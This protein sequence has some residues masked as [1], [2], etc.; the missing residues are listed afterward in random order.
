[1]E[2]GQLWPAASLPMCPQPWILLGFSKNALKVGLGGPKEDQANHTD[3]KWN[4]MSQTKTCQVD[5]KGGCGSHACGV[6]C[7][8][9]DEESSQEVQVYEGEVRLLL[10]DF[11][12]KTLQ[13]ILGCFVG[14]S[15]SSLSLPCGGG[16]L[17]HFQT[18]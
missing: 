3:S 5:L 18:C 4:A 17:L 1:M 13:H 12:P 10:V 6:C 8:V 7:L 11:Q 9:Q 2:V 14:A 15:K 16:E